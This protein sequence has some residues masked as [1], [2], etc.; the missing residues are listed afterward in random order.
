MGA[1]VRGVCGPYGYLCEN[2]RREHR[3]GPRHVHPDCRR[4]LKLP[5]LAICHRPVCDVGSDLATNLDFSHSLGPRDGSFLALLPRNEAWPRFDGH[6]DR[7]LSVVLVAVFA[8]AFLG[9]RPSGI[10]LI[11]AGAAIIAIKA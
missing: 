10:G 11:A 3:L 4:P 8:F 1:T 5:R 6:T 9:E 7:Q 2:R